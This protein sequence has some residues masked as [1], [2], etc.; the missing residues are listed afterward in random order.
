[1]ASI[2][3][4]SVGFGVLISVALCGCAQFVA[5]D[6]GARLV[7]IDISDDRVVVCRLVKVGKRVHLAELESVPVPQGAVVEGFVANPGA[8]AAILNRVWSE[9]RIAET[10]VSVSIRG[11]EVSSDILPLPRYGEPGFDAAVFDAV[12]GL[13][14]D[15]PDLYQVDAVP[16]DPNERG[17]LV[18]SLLVTV[19]KTQLAQLLEAVQGAGLEPLVV[20]TSG[21]ALSNVYEMNYG[22]PETGTVMLVH[23]GPLTSVQVTSGGAFAFA[24][25][26]S[27]A[28][29]DGSVSVE[30]GIGAVGVAV[31][32]WYL[33]SPEREVDTVYLSGSADKL[34][35]I[36]A[37]SGEENQISV[38]ILDPFLDIETESSDDATI[39]ERE[40]EAAI[41]VGL[42]FRFADEEYPS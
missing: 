22:Y 5:Q 3:T 39:T 36:A 11:P 4:V 26:F 10:R 27:V 30:T 15:P 2:R 25:D 1:V 9:R 37:R 18:E 19:P 12:D 16:I 28:A 17:D 35:E 29:P 32:H 21:G 8:I 34:D 13:R 14:R 20:D 24:R 42:A 7:G 38:E 41:A 6:E 33:R 31:N 23:L 40:S